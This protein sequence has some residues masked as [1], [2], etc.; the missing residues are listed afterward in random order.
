MGMRM[1]PHQTKN[2]ALLSREGSQPPAWTSEP[3]LLMLGRREHKTH[4][5]E[6]NCQAWEASGTDSK[7]PCGSLELARSQKLFV[8][9]RAP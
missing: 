3:V 8:A 1:Q 5:C 4:Y 2:M 9:T 7:E 6:H